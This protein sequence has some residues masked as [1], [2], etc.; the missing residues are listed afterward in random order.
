MVFLATHV[1]IQSAKIRHSITYNANGFCEWLK[2]S[3]ADTVGERVNY[4]ACYLC[5]LIIPVLVRI[6]IV[7]L[8]CLHLQ[9]DQTH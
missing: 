5:Y 6:D 4:V 3:S 7:T 9:I 1:L 2:K 8:K